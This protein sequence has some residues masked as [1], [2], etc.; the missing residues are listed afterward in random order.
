MTKHS[1]RMTPYNQFYENVILT[2]AEFQIFC[3]ELNPNAVTSALKIEPSRVVK[4]GD[5]FTSFL[6]KTRIEK[7]NYWELSSEGK[8]SSLDLRHHIDYLLLQLE[9]RKSELA[10]LQQTK[11]VLMRFSC[12]WHS[13]GSGG[14]I[15]W[16]EQMKGLADLNLECI[17]KVAQVEDEDESPA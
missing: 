17:F 10:I 5:I 8:P 14:P 3:G 15:L 7:T 16:P 12:V 4:R 2:Y 6:G 1:A 11:G 13:R 9:P